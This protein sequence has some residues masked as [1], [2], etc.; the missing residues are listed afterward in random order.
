MKIKS[1]RDSNLQFG[2]SNKMNINNRKYQQDGLIKKI[3]IGLFIAVVAG[4]ILH[5][6]FTA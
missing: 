3:A 5:F 4:I 6:S 1:G 2:D